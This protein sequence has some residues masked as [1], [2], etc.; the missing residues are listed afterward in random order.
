MVT[1]EPY[2]RQMIQT[3]SSRIGAVFHY[4][5]IMR[6]AAARIIFVFCSGLGVTTGVGCY[7]LSPLFCYWFFGSL[8]FWKYLHLT[9]PIIRFTYH[10]AYLCLKG[11]SVNYIPWTAPPMRGPDIEVVRINPAWTNGDS[12]E[13]CGKCCRKIKCPFQ[14]KIKSHCLSYNSFYWRYF[15]CGRYP[16]SQAEIDLYECPKW[17]MRR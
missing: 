14:D 15:N 8:R 7:I 10:L 4:M 9:L 3:G 5:R 17:L 2:V 6:W 11:R 16:T 1:I 12:C 13:G